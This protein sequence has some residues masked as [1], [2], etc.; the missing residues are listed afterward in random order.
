MPPIKSVPGVAEQERLLERTR[1]DLRAE[2]VLQMKPDVPAWRKYLGEQFLMSLQ[3]EI[4]LRRK[5][6]AY[7][8]GLPAKGSQ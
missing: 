2:Q 6:L 3:A 8:K 1:A 7:T 4:K 5:G